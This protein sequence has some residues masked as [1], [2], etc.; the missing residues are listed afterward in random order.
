MIPLCKDSVKYPWFL[1]HFSRQ[2]FF[3]MRSNFQL[4]KWTWLLMPLS[5]SCSCCGNKR[6][7]QCTLT[8]LFMALYHGADSAKGPTSISPALFWTLLP[9]LKHDPVSVADH[10]A[11]KVDWAVNPRC[12]KPNGVWVLSAAVA[13]VGQ[14]FPL[15]PWK[16]IPGLKW[17]VNFL[18]FLGFVTQ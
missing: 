1:L 3:K 16:N 10:R 7:L 9:W 5:T 11:H 2:T 15:C 14:H 12:R 17:Y 4:T 8:A 6:D 13:V 18:S